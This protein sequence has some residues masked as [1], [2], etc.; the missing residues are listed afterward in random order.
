MSGRDRRGCAACGAI[1]RGFGLIGDRYYCPTCKREKEDGVIP[2]GTVNTLGA[3]N[4][5]P[6]TPAS[7]QT[8]HGGYGSET[9]G[10]FRS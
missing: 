7:E 5:H 8:Y 2:R 3:G 1:G 6:S 10:R 9:L 4:P